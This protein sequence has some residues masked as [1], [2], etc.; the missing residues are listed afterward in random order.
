MN[1]A[2]ITARDVNTFARLEEH[3][4]SIRKGGK[5][6]IQFKFFACQVTIHFFRISPQQRYADDQRIQ[7]LTNQL[8]DRRI[9]YNRRTW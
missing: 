9:C 2:I 4:I 6:M 5:A 3:P 7:Q 8:I 1:T